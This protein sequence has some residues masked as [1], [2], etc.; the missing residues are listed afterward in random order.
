M[1]EHACVNLMA[2]EIFVHADVLDAERRAHGMC[3]SLSSHVTLYS[4]A[5]MVN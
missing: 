3:L 5:F 4:V 2:V 1:I